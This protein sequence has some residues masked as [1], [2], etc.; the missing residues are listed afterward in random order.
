MTAAHFLLL[1]YFG[2]VGTV[3]VADTASMHLSRELH[4]REAARG[5]GREQKV[6]D[7]ESHSIMGVSLCG[8]TCRERKYELLAFQLVAGSAVGESVLEYLLDVTVEHGRP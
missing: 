4:L 5:F 1:A 6:V 3:A 2:F 8:R 7:R